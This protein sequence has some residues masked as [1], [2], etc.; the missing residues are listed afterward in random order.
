MFRINVNY[1]SSYIESLSISS[2]TYLRT[3]FFDQ[4]HRS[5]SLNSPCPLLKLTYFN[6]LHQLVIS[7]NYGQYKFE[8]TSFTSQN[9]VLIFFFCRE[10]N[11][12][13]SLLRPSEKRRTLSEL[14]PRKYTRKSGKRENYLIS[15]D[16]EV[17]FLER[18]CLVRT[19]VIRG[20]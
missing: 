13:L 11:Q 3:S 16:S 12:E 17:F 4:V 6:K 20:S 1:D 15:F 8:R 14:L 2:K 19:Q 7:L 10:R 18:K 9:F 5:P